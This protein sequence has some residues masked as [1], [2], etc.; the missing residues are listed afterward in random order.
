MKSFEDISKSIFIAMVIML[1]IIFLYANFIRDNYKEA[2]TNGDGIVTRKEMMEYMKKKSPS[3]LIGKLK[4]A[5]LCGLLRGFVLGYLIDGPNGAVVTSIVYGT[6]N[7]VI[8]WFEFEI[9]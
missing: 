5:F 9:S 6:I 3:N 2:D 7:P 4:S 8:S 1:I